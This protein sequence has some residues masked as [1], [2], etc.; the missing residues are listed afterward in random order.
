MLFMKQR[1][2]VSI[3]YQHWKFEVEIGQKY[4]AKRKNNY[5]YVQG[6]LDVNYFEDLRAI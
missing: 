5:R 6:T 1:D 2:W 3:R 4:E